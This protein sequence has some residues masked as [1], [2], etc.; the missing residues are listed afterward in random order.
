[1]PLE[2]LTR[3]KTKTREN[4]NALAGFNFQC[5]S[6]KGELGAEPE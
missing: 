1:M 3:L 4:L 5:L 6:L 2:Q